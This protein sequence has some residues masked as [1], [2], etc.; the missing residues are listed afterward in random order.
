[1][2]IWQNDSDWKVAE[3]ERRSITYNYSFV[4]YHW[5]LR[6]RTETRCVFKY[7][8]KTRWDSISLNGLESVTL[9]MI[10]VQRIIHSRGR[11]FSAQSWNTTS[12]LCSIWDERFQEDRFC[13]L[14][15]FG[16]ESKMVVVCMESSHLRGIPKLLL[17][18]PRFANTPIRMRSKKKL[19]LKTRK[20]RFQ[21]CFS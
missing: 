15:K 11:N 18:S 9:V 7:V 3:I 4:N 20:N 16:P 5:L 21:S 19:R 1:M 17:H 6:Q 8:L 13:K 10:P 2:Y 12:K 14:P